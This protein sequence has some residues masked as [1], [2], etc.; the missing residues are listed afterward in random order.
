MHQAS[1]EPQATAPG[2]GGDSL[3]GNIIQSFLPP[4][5]LPLYP[6]PPHCNTKGLT[7]LGELLVR[8]MMDKKMIV[9]PDHLGVLARNNVL[10]ILESKRYSGVIS[11]HSWS[12]PDAFPRIFKLGGLVIPKPNSATSFVRNWKA[13]SAARTA[14]SSPPPA[15]TGCAWTRR[16][17]R[18]SAAA[19]SRG[20]AGGRGPTASRAPTRCR[21]PATAPWSPSRR[22]SASA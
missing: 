11:S 19:G 8:R 12:T 6:D 16:P 15:P 7:Q 9:D 2:T 13:R 10:S 21:T 18:R 17:T 14:G 4:G 22:A 3:A 20:R 1:D 5:T